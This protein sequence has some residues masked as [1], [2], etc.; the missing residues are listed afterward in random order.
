MDKLITIITV[1]LNC[2]SSIQKTIESVINQKYNSIEHIIIDGGSH[3]GTVEILENYEKKD[4][5]IKHIS[6]KDNGI[7]DAMNKGIA[8]ASGQVIYFLN[9]GDTLFDNNVL[10]N[11]ASEIDIQK[12]EIVFGDVVFDSGEYICQI[13]KIN[14]ATILLRKFPNHQSIFATRKCFEL[15]KNFNTK[16]K[17]CADYEWL[18][19]ALKNK[20]KF[21][22][23]PNRIC[24]YDTNG[25]SSGKVN[26]LK[27]YKEEQLA[28]K[29]NCTCLTYL[30]IKL[31]HSIGRIKNL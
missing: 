30:L 3:D 7:Y 22:Y 24:I 12:N 10:S 11:I 14:L 29:K 6:E 18:L 13:Q 19:R 25:V 27:M 21:K 2:Y 17:I 5:R 9:S 16:Y 23:I 1:C 31:R 26:R 4:A 15:L 20:V 8:M 28:V